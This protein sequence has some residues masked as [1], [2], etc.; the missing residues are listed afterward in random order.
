VGFET[1]QRPRALVR[2][3]VKWI[4][5]VLA[6][7]KGIG[8]CAGVGVAVSGMV[9]LEAGLCFS[10]TLG[11]RDVD[12]TAPLRTSIR[13][14]VVVENSCKACVLAQVWTV[15]GDPQVDG[16]VAFV[17]VS[18]GVGVGIAVDGKLL[19][20]SHN[21]AGEY[22][23]VTLDPRGPRCS[24][25][26]R[27]CFEAFVSKR[28]L[29]ARYLRSDLSWPASARTRGMSVEHVIARARAGEGRAVE[30]LR[31][32]SRHIG[33]GFALIVKT[34][35]PKRIYVG[36]EITAAWD[37]VSP[38][39]CET[40]R[41]ESLVRNGAMAEILPVALGEHPRLRGAAALVGT[42]AFAAPD[43]A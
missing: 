36:G 3:L 27:G 15:R 22:G 14:P 8:K 24:C 37:L 11:W 41:Q 4:G 6:G 20:G 34:V 43:R 16:P 29:I 23:H 13:L 1:P 2:E 35:D 31:E 30:A 42:P 21:F 18:D 7:H 5:R 26:H 38:G 25:G 10:P 28:A 9:D 19:R 39:V 33:R 32:T 12:L 40:L 17:N